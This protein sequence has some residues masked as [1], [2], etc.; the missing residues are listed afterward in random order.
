MEITSIVGVRSTI[1]IINVI[2]AIKCHGYKKVFTSH[3]NWHGENMKWHIKIGICE[4]LI[5]S[6]WVQ[7]LNF[8]ALPL[9]I[10]SR[11]TFGMVWWLR[12][13]VFSALSPYRFEERYLGRGAIFWEEYYLL[14]RVSTFFLFW[15]K[16]RKA[17]FLKSAYGYIVWQNRN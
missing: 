14:F 9:E 8:K 2:G 3:N 4:F 11:K 5:S 7:N 16:A 1:F 10:K 15:G 6:R 13:G 17:N 12:W